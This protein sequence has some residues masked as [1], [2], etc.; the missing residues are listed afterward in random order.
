MSDLAKRLDEARESVLDTKAK[1][2]IFDI[3]R[4]KG[5]AQIEFWDLGD[6]KNRRIH[7][8]DVVE[9]PRTICVAWNWYGDKRIEF[10][11]EWGDTAQG[12]LDRIWQA[13]DEA[14]I[15]VGHNVVGFD[16]KKLNT[17]WR[18]AG[19]NPPSPYKVVDTLKE[20]RKQFG[21]ESKT[22]DALCQR[23]GLTGKTDRYDVETARAALDGDRK[24]QIELQ[25]YN[26]GDILATLG[27]YDRIRGWMPNHPHMGELDSTK[28]RCNQCGGSDLEINGTY[29]AVQIR[30]IQYR[31]LTCGANLRGSMHSK[32]STVR[33]AR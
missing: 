13:F 5:Q 8:D 14:D 15:V 20:A 22:L 7:A 29:L 24:A 27:L 16:I 12:M 32:S 1:I 9:W 30:Y 28:D 19:M 11:S 6:Y 18:D 17:E 26:E 4:M 21:D 31:C 3:E 25:S 33:G 10:A 23:L 2:L